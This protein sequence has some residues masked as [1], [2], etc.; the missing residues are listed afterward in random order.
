M[1][2][3]Y[4]RFG[5]LFGEPVVHI[6]RC[7]IAAIEPKSIVL[8]GESFGLRESGIVELARRLFPAEWR[9]RRFTLS[10]TPLKYLRYGPEL[11]TSAQLL[12]GRRQAVGYDGCSGAD[13]FRGRG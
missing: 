7:G 10:M 5:R 12:A 11:L 1:G 9:D 8:H 4:H 2:H 3:H 6:E 13:T